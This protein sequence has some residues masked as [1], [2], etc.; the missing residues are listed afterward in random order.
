MSTYACEEPFNMSK[1]GYT[2]RFHLRIVDLLPWRWK[3]CRERLITIKFIILPG[4]ILYHMPRL[5]KSFL[6]RFIKK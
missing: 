3:H 4:L 2:Q 6:W 1:K 5:Q